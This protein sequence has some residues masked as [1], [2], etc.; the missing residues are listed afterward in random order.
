MKT[1]TKTNFRCGQQPRISTA[2]MRKNLLKIGAVL[3]LSGGAVLSAMAVDTRVTLSGHVPQVIA[4]LNAEGN[5]PGTN[6]LT[7]AIG[8]PLRNTDVLSNLLQ[9]VYD[10]AST[11]YHKYLTPEQF[12]AQF[13]PPEQDYQSVSNF[14]QANG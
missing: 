14:A 9:Q 11:N 13:G 3:L 2:F 6:N 5:L 1:E 4:H 8:L 7:L 12:T 10:P